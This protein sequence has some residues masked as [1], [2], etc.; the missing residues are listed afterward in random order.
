[1]L[2]EL[3][4]RG[5]IFFT[6]CLILIFSSNTYAEEVVNHNKVFMVIVN[7]LSLY[8]IEYMSN[9]KG[10]IEDGSIG[11]MN[12]RGVNGY[13]GAEGFIT[14]NTSAKANSSYE[15]ANSFNLDKEAQSIYKRRTGRTTGEYSVAN[16]EINRLYNINNNNHYDPVIGALGDNLQNS[17]YK[18][19]VF[20]NSDTAEGF[21]RT[22]CLIAINS[23]GL[24]DFGNVDDILINDDNYP[25][26]LRTD[27]NK[28]IAEINETRLNA[29]FFV[30]ETGDLDRLSKYSNN[31]SED[32]FLEQRY[33]ILK[34]ID[35]FVGGLMN[36]IIDDKSMLMIV[37]PNSPEDRL[38]N[39]KL[40]PL[41]I[42]NGENYR[43]ILT[44]ATTR[45]SGIVANIDIAP[46]ITN[47]LDANNRNFVGHMI[48]SENNN[49][50]IN[51]IAHLNNRAN[52][53]SGLRAP[54]LNTYSFLIIIAFILIIFFTL[55]KGTYKS[56]LI[57]L[58]KFLLILVLI[59]PFVFLIT[60]YFE[61]E[62]SLSYFVITLLTTVGMLSLLYFIKESNRIIFLLTITYLALMIDLLLGGSLLRYSILSYDP[63]IGARYF[64]IGNEF[65]G[66]ILSAMVLV[67]A[68]Y[69]DKTKGNRLFLLILLFTV[70]CI[71]H[72]SFG[73]NV[74]GTISVI[75]ASLFFL[76]GVFR[77]KIDLK[78]IILIGILS[79]LFILFIGAI[80]IYVNPNPTHLGRI[81][82]EIAK[83]GPTSIAGVILRKVQMNIKLIRSSTWSKVLILT[84]LAE[85]YILLCWKKHITKVIQDNIFFSIGIISVLMGSIIGLLAN[86]SGVLLAAISN[87]YLLAIL[88]YNTLGYVI[89][90]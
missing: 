10:I 29:S 51:F 76:L 33:N 78:K 62:S 27:Y 48:T 25:Y 26:G 21:I 52:L 1:M 69:M 37:S 18:T 73:A 63:I 45:R 66:V 75:F 30:I 40:S 41:I 82:M 81:L 60:A 35:D 57:Q 11:L 8:D 50:K 19:A 4:K 28:M 59:L 85:I 55:L 2:G 72:P 67:T 80:D 23:K 83:N 84:V 74:G 9:L 5:I 79:F 14:I 49:D 39:S 90:K 77:V 22:N 24:I 89:E 46:T 20:G 43:G 87:T 70:L 38:D 31:L 16:I 17:G 47:Y 13:K 86:D 15:T 68:F 42:W 6:L 7:R 34:N 3:Q 12:T 44:S 36:E 58:L 56:K 61:L 65:V 32:M 54:Y 64:G 88:M 71:S 53:V